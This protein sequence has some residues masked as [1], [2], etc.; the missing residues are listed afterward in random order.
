MRPLSLLLLVSLLL[1]LP[2]QPQAQAVEGYYRYP[3]L[4]GDTLVFTAHGDLYAGSVSGGAY[5]PLTTHAGEETNAA[6]SP[7]GAQVAFTAGYEGPAEVYVMPLAGGTPRRLTYEGESAFVRGWTPDGR[8]LY[9]SRRYSTLP[10]R[11][12]VAIDPSTRARTLLPLA[13]A[14]QGSFDPDT[15]A[16]FFTRLA[17]QGS[18]TKRYKGGTAQQLWKLDRGASE[19]VPLTHDYA[20][21]SR[22]PMWWK[23]RLYFASDRDGTMNLWS[24]DRNGGDLKRITRHRDWDLLSPSLDSGRVIYQSGADLHLLELTSGEDRKLPVTITSDVE[25]TREKWVAKPM[26]YLT[27]AHLSP[28]GERV[29][30]TARGQIFVAPVGQGRLAQVTRS[31]KSR[32]R[33]AMFDPDGKSVLALSDTSGETEWWRF[34]ANGVG[35]PAQIT[36]DAEVL[37]LSGAV[38]PDGKWIASGDKNQELWLYDLESGKG[39][40]I[41]VSPTNEY[42]DFAWSPDSR[43]L[44]FTE[45]TSNLMSRIAL[46]STKERRSTPI[47]SERVESWSPAWSRD[48]R[49]LYFLSER[50]FRSVVGSP[51]GSRQPEPFFDRRTKIY[52]LSLRKGQRSPFDPEDELH[53]DADKPADRKPADGAKSAAAEV[54]IDLDGIR[55][56]L[57]EVPVPAGNYDSLACGSNRLLWISRDAGAPES[58]EVRAAP[59]A[60]KDVEAKTLV[61]GVRMFELSTDGKKLLV[62]KADDLYVIDSGAAAPASLEKKKVDLSGWSFALDPREEW[63]QM[64]VEAWRLERD[65]FYDRGLHGADWKAVLQRHL[66]LLARVTDRDELSDLLGQMVSELSALHIFVYGGDARRGTD[67]VAPASLGAALERD[68]EAG[69]YRV[70]HVYA[71]DED[72]PENLSPLARPGVEVGEGDVIQAINGVDLLTVDDP[73]V[74]LRNQVGKQ[75]LLKV[76]EKDEK[77]TRDVIAVPVSA[78]RARSLRYDDWEQSRRSRVETTGGGQIGY[79]HLRAMGAADIAQWT[80]DFYPV[81]DRSGLIVDVRHNNGGNIDSWILERLMRR[82]W[83]YW[84]PR[85]GQPYWNMQFAFRGHVVVLCDESTASDGEAFA[86][87]FKRLGLG[88]VI[89]TRTWGG[90]IWLSSSNF[91]VDAGIATAAETGVYGPEG[92]WLIEGHGVEPDIVVDNLPRATFDDQDA[93]LQ[94]AIAYLQ[95][96]IRKRPVTIPPAPPYPRKALP[97]PP[98]P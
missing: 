20:G 97:P 32:S 82:A 45:G 60:R 89:G 50:S 70:T 49:W 16:L 1:A 65:Y 87:G 27:T 12:L 66:P 90:E 34:P 54:E 23:G 30:L 83:F 33:Q 2:A 84:Q 77:R 85:V 94:A 5:R 7:D 76:R 86:E 51:W 41:A 29:V 63:R 40:R 18:H 62:R 71:T 21:T 56:R 17:H 19:A 64:L 10:N 74:L 9:S 80:R 95:E 36:R 42:T 52:E 55:S 39:A 28:D 91:L 98:M 13:Q 73:A 37:R 31:P 44:A 38:S 3:A 59:I 6:I 46:Y 25:Q 24:M 4:H 67:A 8:V 72:Y 96:E 93:Q 14:D 53:P 69:G 57:R 81:F 79:V 43:W 61:P 75:V 68:T 15:G 26:E 92:A 11:Q 22:D 47:T 58:A 35:A 48:G 78:G 88:K